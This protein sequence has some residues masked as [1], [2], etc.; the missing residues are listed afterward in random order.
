MNTVNLRVIMKAFIESQFG[1]YS[2]VWM[3][4]SRTL[5]NKINRLHERA[6]TLVYKDVHLSFQQLIDEDE[7]V[8]IH[9]RHLQKLATEMYKLK[10]NI[11]PIIMKTILPE[12]QNPYLLRSGNPFHTENIRTVYGT[13]SFRGPKT[14]AMVPNHGLL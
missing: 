11:S 14:W 5:N 3:F 8:T 1:Y 9:H 13:I 12:S 4:H 2:L 10:N 6:L 7:S